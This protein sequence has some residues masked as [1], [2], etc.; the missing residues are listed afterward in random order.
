M[1]MTAVE[2]ALTPHAFPYFLMWK[3][4]GNGFFE[5]WRT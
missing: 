5:E 1:D 2:F 4:R 3:S